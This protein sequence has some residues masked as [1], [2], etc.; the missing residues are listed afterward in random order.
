MQIVL[1]EAFNLSG[2]FDVYVEMVRQY[3]LSIEAIYELV[4]CM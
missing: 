3:I 4:K 1:G 2:G